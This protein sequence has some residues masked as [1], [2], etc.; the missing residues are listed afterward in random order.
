M[1]YQQSINL[2]R[3]QFG[4][5][6][7]FTLFKI[8]LTA[9]LI[10]FLADFMISRKLYESFS[11]A[12]YRPA[13][14]A[15]VLMFLNIYLQ[16][17]RWRL[18]CE[19]LLNEW[20]RKK[21]FLSLFHGFPAGAVTPGRIGEYFA[22]GI[23]L[24]GN[25]A[26]RIALSVF[27][28]KLFPLIP[29]FLIGLL[30]FTLFLKIKLLF[31][32][33]LFILLSILLLIFFKILKN[34]SSSQRVKNGW[35]KKISGSIE[36]FNKMDRSFVIRMII[37]SVLFYFCYIMQYAL[38]V[39]AFSGNLYMLKY[40]WAGSLLFFIKAFIPPVTYGDLG[41]REGVSVYF[42]TSLGENAAAGLN[43]SLFLFCFNLLIPS[44]AG[45]I[46]LFSSR[47]LER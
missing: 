19:C 32:F 36:L 9:A 37:L 26:S 6:S 12:D 1:Y 40:M 23:E 42:I 4:R 22:R 44:I 20:D 28:E 17:R 35:I 25:S 45:A 27:I 29:V 31:I 34:L 24:Q 8:V 13:G 5:S 47:R 21:I 33:F 11:S 38:L 18:A 3:S 10:I 14:F 43:A 15:F 2:F 41:I 30:S 16:Y 46:L 39:S 7:L